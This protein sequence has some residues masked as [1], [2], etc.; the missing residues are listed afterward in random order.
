MPKTFFL[1]S[2]IHLAFS[3]HLSSVTLSFM[4]LAFLKNPVIFLEWL[5]SCHV[6]RDSPGTMCLS[7]AMHPSRGIL[8]K[9]A[10]LM[11]MLAFFSSNPTARGSSTYPSSIPHTQTLFCSIQRAWALSVGN[12]LVCQLN[13]LLCK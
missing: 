7:F 11:S 4:T 6:G 13:P 9:P 8:C 10:L 1:C 3:C 5:I 12:I 2:K